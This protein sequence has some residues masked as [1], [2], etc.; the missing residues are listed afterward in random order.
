MLYIF[1]ILIAC[2]C[3]VEGPVELWV[4]TGG[5]RRLEWFMLV[6]AGIICKLISIN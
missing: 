6:L 2:R 5:D 4:G 1:N 3:E